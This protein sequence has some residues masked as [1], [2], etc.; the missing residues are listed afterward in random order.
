MTKHCFF[1]AC[2]L[3]FS[4]LLMAQYALPKG[5]AQLNGGVG[6]SSWGLPFYVGVDVGVHPD[7][8]VGGELSFRT[9]NE[10]WRHRGS[11]YN[12]R[13]SVV[14]VAGNFNYHFNSLLD[15]DR[16][17]DVY[18]GINIGF[19]SWSEPR[20]NNFVYDGRYNSGLGVG[21][22]VGA[23]YYFSKKAAFNLELGG[24]NAFAGG[25][26]GLSILL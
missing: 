11:T 7:I 1:V 16:E 8:S 23:R 15:I 14:G 5:K 3:L 20:G 17:W 26:F 9:Y 19:Y 6:L 22:Q 12:F 4:P 2:F 25:K 18:A 10:T 24:G 13:R 21:G